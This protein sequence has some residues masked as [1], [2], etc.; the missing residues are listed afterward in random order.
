MKKEIYE[1]I[2]QKRDFSQL[3][4]KDVEKVF[5][6]FEKRQVSDEEKIRL[7]RDM[8]RKV[9]SAFTSKKLLSLKDKPPEWILKKHIST[10]ERLP[11]Y[12]QV[13]NKI[14]KGFDKL[15]VFDLGAG[16]NGFSY[17][18]FPQ[19]TSYVGIEAIG[20]LVDLTNYYFKTR[21]LEAGAIHESLFELEKIKKYLSQ[22]KGK[23]IVFLFKTIDSLEMMEKN[24]SKKFLSEIVPLVDLVV[25]S[26]ATKSLIKKTRFKVKRTWIT[27]F[28]KENFEV[29][30]DFEIGGERYLSFKEIL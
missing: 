4:K 28:I 14:L 25:V 21:G 19:G 27:N 24:Y 30:D 18:Y 2:V 26:F 15:T 17:N 5:S 16:I 6:L 13:Y 1:K 10:R 7:T 9:F 12:S 23:K 11:Y 8:L 29:L 3:P 22:V 20:Q